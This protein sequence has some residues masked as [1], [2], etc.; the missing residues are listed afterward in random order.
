MDSILKLYL[1]IETRMLTIQIGFIHPMHILP[2]MFLMVHLGPI[3]DID[4]SVSSRTLWRWS[5]WL[6]M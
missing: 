4:I 6:A 3:K 1:A 2:C 5:R